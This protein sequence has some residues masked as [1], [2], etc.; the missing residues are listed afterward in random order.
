[1]TAQSRSDHQPDIYDITIIGAGPVGLY[2]LYYAGLRLMKAKVIDM[3]GEIGG[4]LMALYPEK[5]IYD[6]AGFPKVLA[7]DLVKQLKDQ[8]AQY[9]Q[10]VCLGEKVVG[11]EDVTDDQLKVVTDKGEHLSRTVVICAGLGAYIPRSLDIP[12]VKELENRGVYHFV[13]DPEIFR[14]KR[15]LV[16]GGGDAAFDASLM[17]ESI[18]RSVIH[19]HRND[20]F[21]AYEDTVEKVRQSRVDL[22]VPF[23]ELQRIEGEDWVNRATIVNSRTDETLELEVD[24][25]FLN[26][27]FL[28]NLGP[29]ED[30]GLE[31][32]KNAI[33]VDSRMRTN[34]PGIFA[35]G[36][37]VT[38]DG[39]LKLISTGCGEVA[40][41]VNNAKNYIDPKAKVSPGHSTDKHVLARRKMA[42]MMSR[43]ETGK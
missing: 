18:A 31:I 14:D 1:M 11:I 37:I 42:R 12:N 7:K 13:R 17:L 26:L 33:V 32:D 3:L 40:V 20:F 6:V 23:W 29:I 28:T 16:V 5:Y 25:I 19:I 10:T 43:D 24:A 9:P 34:R 8:A 21:N 35:A 41:A 27:G 39:K 36:D 38:Y 15:V 4:G 22:K 30:W 2:G